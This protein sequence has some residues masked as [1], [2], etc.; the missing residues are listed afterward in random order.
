MTAGQVITEVRRITGDTEE[1]RWSSAN[2]LLSIKDGLHETK[3]KRP[4]LWIS[5]PGV[6][7]DPPDTLLSGDV[8]SLPDQYKAALANY[9]A[10]R[11]YLEES[12]DQAN[13]ERAAVHYQ[14]FREAL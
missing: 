12:D 10:W 13:R 1:T 3:R 7:L 6:M 9:A 14:F 4:D 5:G 2:L 11:L 8:L